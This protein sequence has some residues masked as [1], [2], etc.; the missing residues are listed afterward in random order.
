VALKGI[1]GSLVSAAV[2]ET[3]SAPEAP[4]GELRRV[5]RASAGAVGP[6]SSARHVFDMLLLP[7]VRALGI[8]GALTLDTAAAL[9]IAVDAPAMRIAIAAAGGWNADL[10]RLRQLTCQRVSGLPRW[11]IGTNGVTLRVVDIARAYARRTLDFD[12]A[13][14]VSDDRALEALR[15]AFER[16]VDGALAGLERLVAESERHRAATGR[17][18]QTGVERALSSLTDGF[19]RRRRPVTRDA[20]HADAL[21]VVYRI[22]F[23]LFADARGIDPHWHPIYRDSYT[24]ESL[25]PIVESGRATAR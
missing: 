21:T 14:I 18:L 25:R 6:A 24:I 11:W 3:A 8:H 23:L 20:A 9:A 10:S 1:S 19:Q 13:L 16:G 2:L 15:I 7:A 22:L 5:L 17:S 12:L 4:A